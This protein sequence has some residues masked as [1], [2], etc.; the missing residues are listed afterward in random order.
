MAKRLEGKT[1]LITGAGSGM[2][3]AMA[4]LFS[5]EG[6]QVVCADISGAQDAVA[7]EI[8][9]AAVGVQADVSRED[10]VQAMVTAAEQAFGRIDVLVNNA[11]FGGAR[12]P[13]HEQTTEEWDRVHGVNLR[14]VFFCLKYG[15]TSM[16]QTGGGSVVNIA[17]SSALVGWRHHGVYGAAK[18]GVVQLTKIAALDYA[19]HGI[20]VNA[21]CP[22]T[23]WT[24][25]VASSQLHVEPPSDAPRAS[26]IPIDRWGLA[27]EIA[28]AALFLA[29]DEAAYV[30]GTALP[31]DGGYAIGYPG[32]A[33]VP[34][35]AAAAPKPASTG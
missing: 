14:G 10:E 35:A 3:R 2:G 18:A 8:G 21:I 20:R 19:E 7:K 29:S 24:G 27:S 5:A 13:V 15:I 11:G 4:Q 17:S 34:R 33:A 9:S 28:T 26:G 32:T 12:L 6:A 25:L 23:I 22:G 1:A 31:V 16:L 30:T